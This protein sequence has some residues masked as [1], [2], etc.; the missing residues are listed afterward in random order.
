MT[1]EIAKADLSLARCWEGHANSLVLIDALGSDS[2]RGRWFDGVSSGARS[3]S[4][5]AASRRPAS[6]A[7]R[8]PSAHGRARRRWLEGERDEV[9]RDQRHRA[10]W[11]ILLV[12]PAGPGARRHADGGGDGLLMLGLPAGRFDDQRRRFLLDPVGMRATVS[13]LVKFDGT[14]VADDDVIGE[15]GSYLRDGWQTAFIPHYAASF[16][17]AAEGRIRLR[18]R[19]SGAPGQGGDPYVPAA[20]RQHA[21]QRRV[22]PPVAAVRRRHVGSGRSRAAQTRRQPRRAT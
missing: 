1:K 11:A 21:C 22:R 3:G 2:Q 16:L 18:G 10:D 19:V 7:R 8:A 14:F 5:G 15:P 17:G 12:D 13:H 9:F 20:S 6:R 4:P